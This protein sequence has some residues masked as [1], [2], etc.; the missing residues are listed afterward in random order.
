MRKYGKYDGWDKNIYL[1]IVVYTVC[2][3]VETE[4][5]GT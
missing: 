3:F 5:V 1:S 4:L 2:C